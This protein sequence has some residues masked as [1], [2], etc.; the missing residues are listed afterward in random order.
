MP[1]YKETQRIV[2]AYFLNALI[3]EPISFPSSLFS[4][5]L[6]IILPYIIYVAFPSWAHT[7][8]IFC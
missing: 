8:I 6:F 2:S 1:V 3:I 4:L 7:F 5:L